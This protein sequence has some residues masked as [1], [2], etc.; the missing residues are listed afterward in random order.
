MQVLYGMWSQ[1]MHS[2]KN[3]QPL[4]SPLK[5]ILW[6]LAGQPHNVYTVA[7]AVGMVFCTYDLKCL[8]VPDVH[9]AVLK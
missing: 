6:Q 8:S 4:S 7:C 9:S 2:G 5:Y 3:S 1:R